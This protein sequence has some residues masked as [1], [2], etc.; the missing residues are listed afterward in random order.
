[1]NYDV[2]ES[3]DQSEGQYSQKFTNTS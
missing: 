3:C 2:T 1:M